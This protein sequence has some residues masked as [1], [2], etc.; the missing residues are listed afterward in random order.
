MLDYRGNP[1]VE[2]E[3]ALDDGTLCRAAVP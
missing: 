2:V 3:I 1:T